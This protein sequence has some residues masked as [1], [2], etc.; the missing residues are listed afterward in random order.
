MNKYIHIVFT[1]GRGP[2][3]C[4][5][6]VFGIQKKFQEYL[7]KDGIPIE[8][9]TQKKGSITKSIET[10][11]FKLESKY[12][13]QV[14][15]WIGSIQWISPSPIRKYS[16]R[17]NWFIK[18]EL[19]NLNEAIVIDL[20][21]IT[22]QT[23][24]ASGPGGQHRNKVETAVRII[25]NPTGIQVSASD[26][27]SQLQN[28]KEALKKLEQ[29]MNKRNMEQLQDFQKDQWSKQIE[30]ERGNPVK[31]FRGMKFQ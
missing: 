20:K 13:L 29:E 10:I 14:Q 8:I 21:S 1:A 2:Q 24:R 7:K 11:V 4:G 25:H 5:L 19:I 3:E 27:K 9:T 6:A 30:I 28:K 12:K 31:T 18:C 23:F 16:K 22:I 17:K 26:S 15:P